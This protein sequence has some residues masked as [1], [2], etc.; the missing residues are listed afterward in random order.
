MPDN[1]AQNP[2][3][4]QSDVVDALNRYDLATRE[5]L[6][7]CWLGCENIAAAD[8]RYHEMKSAKR[9]LDDAINAYTARHAREFQAAKEERDG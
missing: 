8:A 6:R 1:P 3:D 9:A 7:D 5:H 2:T 4:R